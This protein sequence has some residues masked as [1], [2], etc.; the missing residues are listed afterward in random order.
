[1]SIS[2]YGGANSELPSLPYTLR[3][4]TEKLKCINGVSIAGAWQWCTENSLWA[5]HCTLTIDVPLGSKV[6]RTT[7]WYVLVSH[8]YPDGSIR[9]VS[10]KSNGLT[11]IFPH[12]YHDPALISES[13]PWSDNYLCLETYYF[14]LD[15]IGTTI[16]P[17]DW[18]S[19]LQWRFERA[20]V[21]LQR[22][23]INDLFREGD[24]FELPL[25][26]PKS[27]PDQ[28][29]RILVSEGAENLLDWD[30]I[31]AYGFLDFKKYE[32]SNSCVVHA[33]RCPNQQIVRELSWGVQWENC[34]IFKSCGIWIR[35]DKLPVIDPW[36]QPKSWGELRNFCS[37]TELNGMIKKMVFQVPLEHPVPLLIGAPI[38]KVIG[39]QNHLIHWQ[40]LLLPGVRQRY[41]GFRDN[42]KSKWDAYTQC[43]LNN[44]RPLPWITSENW[45]P[46]TLSTR[47]RLPKMLR[48]KKIVLVGVGALGAPLAEHLVRGGVTDLILIDHDQFQ[49]G[50]LVRHLLSMSDIADNKAEAMKNRLNLIN[51]HASVQA[52]PK[53]FFRDTGD[54]E[55]IREADLIIETTASDEVIAHLNTLK[56]QQPKHFV[57]MSISAKAVQFYAFSARGLNF[58]L[59]DFHDRVNPFIQS[60]YNQLKDDDV[61]WEGI[62]CYHPVFEARNDDM[63]LWASVAT[64]LIVKFVR[65]ESETMDFVAMKQSDDDGIPQILKCTEPSS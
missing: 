37:G 17:R 39:G 33:F 32:N 10:A 57:S 19:R 16:E 6:P 51:P 22:A 48:E 55:K 28:I 12:H 60:E 43:H 65:N 5:I 63:G 47:G 42:N 45:H 30:N 11:G 29:N 4:A 52:I 35:L 9:F 53:A 20:L 64:K 23:S 34:Q 62:G 49:A 14:T 1:M 56:W 27:N 41:K 31:I 38:P 21:W 40:A 7:D 61:Q 50:N 44:N 15:R 25:H 54:I 3:E 58:P 36:Q 26:Q 24:Q 13:K 2:G 46:D 59:D 18:H 8:L